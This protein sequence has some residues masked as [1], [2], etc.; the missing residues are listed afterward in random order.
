MWCIGCIYYA[1]MTGQ[2]P[3]K[4][5]TRSDAQGLLGCA[6]TDVNKVNGLDFFDDGH[7]VCI[8]NGSG[9]LSF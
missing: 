4:D 6:D 7:G 8:S 2:T 3:N 1:D 5:Q 9:S